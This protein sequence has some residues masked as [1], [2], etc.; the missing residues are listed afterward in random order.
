MTDPAI[1]DAL[2]AHVAM[3]D[4]DGTIL[5]VNAA[6]RQF[7]SA[8]ALQQADHIVGV[9][10]LQVCDAAEGEGAADAHAVAAGIRRVLAGE[11]AIFVLEYPCHGPDE[12]RWFNVM[13][14]PVQTAHDRG[15][16]VTH[17]NITERHAAVRALRQTQDRF[18]LLSRATND[19]VWD[20]NL[21]TNELWWNEGF[22]GIFG[23]DRGQI[24]PTLDSWTEHIHADDRDRVL[25]SLDDVIAG[26]GTS[27]TAD[28]RF[29]RKNGSYAWVM[30]R[31]YVQRESDGTALR[32][33]GAMTDV[34]THREALHHIAQQA[35]LIEQAHDAIIVRSLTDHIL[36][37]NRGAEGTFGWTADEAIGRR[38]LELFDRDSDDLAKAKQHLLTHGFWEGE[39][40]K[41]HRE[42][43]KV[44]V[45]VR[46][47]LTRT[48]AG[49]PDAILSIATDITERRKIE[50][51]LLRSQRLES[52][53]TMAGG[54]AHDLNNVLAPI[55]MSIEVLKDKVGDA[56]GLNLLET[57][58]TSA[59]RGAELVRQM[60]SFA[61]GV[62]GRRLSVDPTQLVDEMARIVRET[63]PKSLQL[64]L[65]CDPEV[66]A[67]LGDPTQLRQVLMNLCVNARDA[68]SQGGVLTLG[69]SNTVVDQVYV[70]MNPDSSPGP[71]VVLKVTD[72]GEG[73]PPGI[74]DK[75]FEPFFT[76]KDVGKGT[77]LGLSTTFAIV[78][79]HRGFINLYSEV[80]KGT[81][82]KVYLPAKTSVEAAEAVAVDQS[83]LP[84]GH[85]ELILLVDDE[86]AI[87]EVA[88]RTLTRFGY[89]VMC[90]AHGAE[91]VSLYARHGR[92]VAA[93]ITDMAMPIMDGPS[94]I[95]AL[96]SMDPDVRIIGSSGLTTNDGMAKAI[97]A[98]VQFFV[99]KPYTADTLL[100]TL[101]KVLSGGS[102]GA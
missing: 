90:A 70:Q 95:I 11:Q 25:T 84:K 76:T 98:G 24:S 81:T 4:G 16:V 3:L 10:Y 20:W 41:F 97:G 64:K 74:R 93:V 71:Y 1:L 31:G 99:P 77:G 78:K 94:M 91:A 49:V 34:T 5:V 82:F 48:D 80:G 44:L 58:E 89:R 59:L 46:W 28:Y 45:A 7:A 9:N 68:M 35:A 92:E 17:V 30:D 27:W 19:A 13:V 56:D 73:I 83:R 61:R 23:Y 87:R 51:Q 50:A 29:R 22:E 33:I 96:K 55:L 88:E 42:G 14:T 2:P 86:A 101:D 62:E 21:T 47:S 40:E 72:T 36:S 69:L 6:W 63:F 67:V 43:H 52:L 38:T 100:R 12:D 15:V 66:W 39:L 85:G 37:W 57:L 79:S 102:P 8:N 75:I 32:M 18:T 65:K 54:V 26:G 53:G 60:L